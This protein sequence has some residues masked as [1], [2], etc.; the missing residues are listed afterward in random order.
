MDYNPQALGTHPLRSCNVSI[1]PIVVFPGRV[2]YLI[3]GLGRWGGGRPCVSA[4]WGKDATWRSWLSAVLKF[5]LLINVRPFFTMK[6]LVM[7]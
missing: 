7:E 2:P 4:A 3:P 1:D 5:T 6:T